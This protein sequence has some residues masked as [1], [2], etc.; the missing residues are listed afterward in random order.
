MGLLEINRLMPDLGNLANL[1]G[2]SVRGRLESYPLRTV[3]QNCDIEPLQRPAGF[4][5]APRIRK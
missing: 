2:N 1:C 5:R 4:V 3:L